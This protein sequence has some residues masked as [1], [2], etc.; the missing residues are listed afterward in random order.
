M[1]D[2]PYKWQL[3]N[4][5][6][7][8]AL[9]CFSLSVLF[10]WIYIISKLQKHKKSKQNTKFD[11]IS[12]EMSFKDFSAVLMK[13]AWQFLVFCLDREMT[14]SVLPQDLK[15]RL[16]SQ[17][18]KSSDTAGLESKVW[19]KGNEYNFFIVLVA[20]KGTQGPVLNRSKISGNEIDEIINEG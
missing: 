1:P 2:K 9:L 19:L 6:D 14:K 17:G 10:T 20:S 5:N 3:N 11:L 8:Q 16:Y 15:P 12:S 13:K 18:L 4:D 7:L